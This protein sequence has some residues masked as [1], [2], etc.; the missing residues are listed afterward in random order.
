MDPRS[1]RLYTPALS[2]SPHL[3]QNVEIVALEGALLD[4]LY[5]QFHL[6]MTRPGWIY[7]DASVLGVFQKAPGEPGMQPLRPRHSGGE[8]IDD[9]IF[10]DATAE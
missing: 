1:G 9:Q 8:V 5:A 6:G 10:G 2:F 4:V 7:D 3:G